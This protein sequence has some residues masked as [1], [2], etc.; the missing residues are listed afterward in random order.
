MTTVNIPD[1]VTEIGRYA[2]RSCPSLTTIDLPDSITTI[3]RYAFQNCY[4][5]ES[6]NIPESVT[7]IDEGAFY[8]CTN[9]SD[10]TLPSG[11]T[12]INPHT[13]QD[14]TALTNINF[15]AS[16]QAI[17]GEA[18][19]GCTGLTNVVIPDTI[20]RVASGVFRDCTSMVSITVPFIGENADASGRLSMAH[21]FYEMP[22]SVKFITVTGGT[23]VPDS[24]FKNLSSIVTVSLPDTVTSIG[25]E[26]FYGCTNLASIKTP[27]KLKTIGA[28]AF[29]NCYSLIS[30]IIPQTTTG[31]GDKA[32]ENCYKL[33]EV[34]NLSATMTMIQG[35]D[36][37]G[38]IAKY[39]EAIHTSAHEAS[40]LFNVE[41]YVFINIPESTM[42][43][44]LAYMGAETELTLP[45]LATEEIPY[46]NIADYAFYYNSSIKKVTFS[47]EIV[48]VG[49]YAFNHCTSLEEVD[50][51]SA[52][53]AT[54]DTYGF[55][56]CDSLTTV[57]F[58]DNL[59][60]ISDEAFYSCKM[61]KEVYFPGTL[62]HIG[63]KA[64]GDT[65]LT[66]AAFAS[67][68]G[69]WHTSDPEATS[70]TEIDPTQLTN[71]MSAS[72]LLDSSFCYYYWNRT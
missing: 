64:F 34:Y 63:K 25:N 50:M 67:V 44:L 58:S 14:C 9:L 35:D 3:P 65:D 26:A 10:I 71:S 24:A 22:A 17:E 12:T 20:T 40:I 32:F 33:V 37:Q 60:T 59:T 47:S 53:V 28:K 66:E 43:S 8:G 45:T 4:A 13:F 36:S 68:T 54:I 21:I 61:L 57:T 49:K 2:F 30:I 42:P 56:D 18:F 29:T 52:C 70:G 69:W 48:K 55:Y 19:R 72:S 7:V 23:S 51:S 31:I 16:V 38:F 15:P 11:L 39:A 27:A 5:L 1:S 46:Y 41:D 6:I 62:N